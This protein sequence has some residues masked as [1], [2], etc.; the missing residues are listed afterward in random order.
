MGVALPG[1][2]LEAF[3]GSSGVDL[4][5]RSLGLALAIGATEMRLEDMAY[6]YAELAHPSQ[7][8]LSPEACWLTLDALKCDEPGAPIGL[9]CKTG[10]SNGFRD[11][12]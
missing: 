4:P 1:G 8:K 2:G 9:S 7:G 6:L 5:Q 3:L 10:T 12:C 11:G